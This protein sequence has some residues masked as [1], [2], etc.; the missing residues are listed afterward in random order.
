VPPPGRRTLDLGCGEG[1][2]SRDLKALGHDVTGVDASPTMV[3]AAREGDPSLDVALA[4][5]TALP[6]E[7]GA[8]DCAIAFKCLQDVDD[9]E[10]AALE[11]ARVTEPGGR[12]CV[13]LVHPLMSA[14][15]F[16]RDDG[17]SPFEI[18]GSYLEPSIYADEVERDGLEMTFVSAHRPLEAYTE[19]LAAAGFLIERLREP[20]MPAHAVTQPS[21]ARW[22]RFPMFLHLRCV[23]S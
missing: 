13:A 21:R 17:D 4:D 7:D 11:L 14:G 23:R 5:A 20:A 12:L 1:R 9:V 2:V 19:A 16:T 15:R 10:G 22:R 8:F 6:F 3:A 18:E